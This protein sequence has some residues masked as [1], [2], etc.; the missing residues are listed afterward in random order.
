MKQV[1]SFLSGSGGVG[2]SGIALNLGGIYARQGKKVLLIDLNMGLRTLDLLM[3]DEVLATTNIMDVL[4]GKIKLLEAAIPHQD[5]E[6]L[7]L[8]SASWTKDASCIEDKAFKELIKEAREHYDYIFLDLPVGSMTLLKMA[9]NASDFSLIV[10]TITQTGIRNADKIYSI[11][12]EHRIQEV[13]IIFNMVRQDLIKR[14]VYPSLEE[15]S[16][17]FPINVWGI[18]PF[19]DT[20]NIAMEQGTL[21]RADSKKMSARALK[22]ISRRLEGEEIPFINLNKNSLLFLKW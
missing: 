9:I 1:I 17:R 12:R 3:G 20:L 15:V 22:N 19:E 11:F 6:D 4:S 10:S 5:C 18:I 8:L 14:G 16:E 2:K 13:G 21:I 7:Q